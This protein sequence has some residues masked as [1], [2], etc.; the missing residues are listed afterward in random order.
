LHI[1]LL[2]CSIF[3]WARVKL[4]PQG[5]LRNSFMES[6]F[7]IKLSFMLISSSRCVLFLEWPFSAIPRLSVYHERL[8]KYVWNDLYCLQLAPL[9][10]GITFTFTFC[11][12]YCC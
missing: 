9:L 6:R 1:F 3:A 8:Q 10:I 11:C 4:C 7:E 2:S 5:S 12:C